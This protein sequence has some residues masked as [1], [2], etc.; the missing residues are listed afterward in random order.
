MLVFISVMK[1]SC[2]ISEDMLDLNSS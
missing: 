2:M 1:L